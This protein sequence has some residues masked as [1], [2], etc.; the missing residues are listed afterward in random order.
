VI[1]L[2]TIQ[3]VKPVGMMLIA[4]WNKDMREKSITWL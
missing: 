4:G 3:F 2:K 1:N